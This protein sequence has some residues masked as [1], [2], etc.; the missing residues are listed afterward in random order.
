MEELECFAD[1][2]EGSYRYLVGKLHHDSAKTDED[3]FRCFV[4]DKTKEAPEGYEIAQS[5]DATCDGLLSPK[6]GSRTMK[7]YKTIGVIPR[8][9]FP[10]WL[11]LRRHWKS[12]DGSHMYDFNRQ[13]NSFVVYNVTQ[14]GDVV[15]LGLCINQ[16]NVTNSVSTDAFE[17]IQYVVHFTSGWYVS[18]C[19]PLLDL[20]NGFCFD[21][22][23]SGF[24]CLRIY[25]RSN[26]IIEL[27]TGS[28]AK[29]PTDA[30]SQHYFTGNTAKYLTLTSE[31]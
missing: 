24:V 27:Q 10:K 12:L 16:E 18:H 3:R 14:G 31:S 22:S 21:F 9:Q 11:T 2:K 29:Q 6:D 25:K 1:W 30:C 15:R 26:Q 17:I 20:I 4:F 8:C 7:I 28:P 19:L 23:K 5:G 13:N